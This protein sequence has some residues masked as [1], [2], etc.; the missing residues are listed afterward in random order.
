MTEAGKKYG[1]DRGARWPGSGKKKQLKR[2]AEAIK[3]NARAG[4]VRKKPE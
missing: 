1:P 2:N 4:L 3:R